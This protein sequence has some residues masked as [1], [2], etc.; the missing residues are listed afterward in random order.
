[1]TNPGITVLEKCLDDKC[2]YTLVTMAAKRARMISDG[3]NR[4]EGEEEL[5]PVSAAV[6]EIAEGKVKYK[7]NV[8]TRDEVREIKRN[9]NTS[10][11]EEDAETVE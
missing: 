4:T 8:K 7:R 10:I 6:R 11:S 3:K 9:L 2:R 5:K 1:M